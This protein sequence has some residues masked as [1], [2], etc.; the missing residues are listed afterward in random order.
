MLKKC[1]KFIAFGFADSTVLSVLSIIYEV[2]AAGTLSRGLLPVWTI[3]NI[4]MCHT[5][6]CNT[7]NHIIIFLVKQIDISQK[8]ISKMPITIRY[9]YWQYIYI[10]DIWMYWRTALYTMLQATVLGVGNDCAKSKLASDLPV[11]QTKS[12]YLYFSVCFNLFI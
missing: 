1:L 5:A 10:G 2:H 11:F 7:I 4:T 6:K 9:Q 3:W 12:I 8:M